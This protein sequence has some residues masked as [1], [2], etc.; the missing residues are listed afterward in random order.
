MPRASAYLLID[1]TLFPILFT[2]R[3]LEL[4]TIGSKN[5]WILIRLV[6]FFFYLFFFSFKMHKTLTN[7]VNQEYKLMND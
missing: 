4:R 3:I 5:Y 2:S 1:I 7:I 6:I